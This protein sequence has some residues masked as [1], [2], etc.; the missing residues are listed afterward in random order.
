MFEDEIAKFD[1]TTSLIYK[2]DYYTGVI[3]CTTI[4][5]GMLYDQEADG[6]YGLG[7]ATNSRS[8]L[9]RNHTPRSYTGRST[10]R[11]DT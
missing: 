6:L 10:A 4:E 1:A 8:K 3:G 11:K 5:S 2:R 9:K 7:V